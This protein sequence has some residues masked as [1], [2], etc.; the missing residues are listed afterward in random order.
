M[1]A[2][3]ILTLAD[4]R[5]NYCNKLIRLRILF[6]IRLRRLTPFL[7]FFWKCII[8][9]GVCALLARPMNAL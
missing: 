9:A 1:Q 5:Y 2:N 4:E 3:G 6:S 8:N 7:S